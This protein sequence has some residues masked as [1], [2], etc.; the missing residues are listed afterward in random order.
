M[1]DGRPPAR[2]GAGPMSSRVNSVPDMDRRSFMG[3]LGLGALAVLTGCGRGNDAAQAARPTLPPIPASRPGPPTVLSAAPRP[4]Q[5]IAWTVDDGYCEDCVEGYLRFA[6]KTGTALTFLPNGLYAGVWEPRARRMRPLIETGQVQIAN[7]T[8]SH[9]NLVESD[10]GTIQADVEANEQWIQ[11]TFG[12]TSRPYLRPPYGA[13]DDRTDRVVADLGYPS[14]TMWNG[15]LG[16]SGPIEP[17]VLLDQARA[18]LQPGAIVLGHANAPTV[19]DLFDEI[20]SLI[21]ERQL[22][23]VTLD[24]MFGTSRAQG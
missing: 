10:D 13:H 24:T 7:H 23:P 16:D 22:E 2:R 15:T 6:E 14:I 3:T 17:T 1:I 20:C 21:A 4:T 5:Q 8:M 11:R 9:L 18:Y 19:L 12:I